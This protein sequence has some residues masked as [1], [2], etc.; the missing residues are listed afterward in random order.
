MSDISLLGLIPTGSIASV[1]VVIIYLLFRNNSQDR[2]QFRDEVTAIEERHT[3]L[4]QELVKR[5]DAELTNVKNELTRL[6][7]S[8]EKILAAFDKER[9]T[10]WAAED[11]AAQYRK[12]YGRLDSDHG[13]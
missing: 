12:T 1:L 4:N 5:H 8:N 11:L 13:G 2:K 3:K 7:E 9:E 10:R 6:R